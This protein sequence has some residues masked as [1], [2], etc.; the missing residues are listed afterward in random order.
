MESPH[1]EAL[2][3]TGVLDHQVAEYVIPDFRLPVYGT[4]TGKEEL[5]L[6]AF[7]LE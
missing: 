5:D 6:A 4:P 1:L 3:A 7:F 2:C